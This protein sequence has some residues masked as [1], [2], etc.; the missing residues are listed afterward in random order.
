MNVRAPRL[1]WNLVPLAVG[2]R[3]IWVRWVDIPRVKRPQWPDSLS[4]G[5]SPVCYW[6]FDQRPEGYYVGVHTQ[7]RVT[8][9]TQYLA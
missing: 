2:E 5:E 6:E 4:A 1:Q 9:D 7:G 8:P 3:D